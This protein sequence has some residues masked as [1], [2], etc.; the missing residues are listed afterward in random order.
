MAKTKT[1]NKLQKKLTIWERAGRGLTRFLESPF[2][3]K[4]GKQQYGFKKIW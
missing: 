4:K 2:N 1:K 3:K